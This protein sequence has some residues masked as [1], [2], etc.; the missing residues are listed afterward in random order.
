MIILL[1]VRSR[2]RWKLRIR[3]RTTSKSLS[4][5]SPVLPRKCGVN[6]S[7]YTTPV[8][9]TFQTQIYYFFL[10]RWFFQAPIDYF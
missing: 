10:R 1:L 3:D 9:E 2:F 6:I 8:N 7:K 4:L 5:S